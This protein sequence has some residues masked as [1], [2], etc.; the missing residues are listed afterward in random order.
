MNKAGKF[1]LISNDGN[2][3]CFDKD[4]PYK[5]DCANHASAGEFREEGGFS[6]YLEIG[7]N[8][9]QVICW[10]KYSIMSKESTF[11]G[12]EAIPSNSSTNGFVEF[13]KIPAHKSISLNC[14]YC[15]DS[16]H[17]T[18]DYDTE[19]H[20]TIIKCSDCGAVLK[21][22]EHPAIKIYRKAN[23]KSLVSE[24][25]D[26]EPPITQ[27]EMNAVSKEWGKPNEKANP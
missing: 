12:G 4:C 5:R 18:I 15:E 27:E 22:N 20:E 25:M 17:F 6:P 8:V 21:V 9:K 10:S 14:W 16:N 26:G 7:E 3:V 1:E 13:C 24:I 19:N 11:Y 2:T 23:I